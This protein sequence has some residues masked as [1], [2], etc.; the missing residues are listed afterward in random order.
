MCNKN[1]TI[2]NNGK[3][4][5]RLWKKKHI[6]YLNYFE[7]IYRHS[8]GN[9]AGLHVLYVEAFTSRHEILVSALSGVCVCVG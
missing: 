9:N 1:I 4:S 5:Q 6:S 8:S 7:H 3:S 2:I